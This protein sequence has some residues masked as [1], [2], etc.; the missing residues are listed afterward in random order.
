MN[1][2]K[3]NSKS[4]LSPEEVQKMREELDSMKDEITRVAN[5]PDEPVNP[6]DSTPWRVISEYILSVTIAISLAFLINTFILLNAK[7]PSGSMENT[8]MTGDRIFGF[9]LAYMF[10]EPERGDIIIFKFP[11]NEKKNYIKRVI[12]LPGETVTIRDGL[13]YINDNTVPLDEPYLAE[14]PYSLD[15]GPYE[16]PEDHYFMLGDNRNHSSDSRAWKNTFVSK[17]KILAKAFIRYW[18]GVR[19]YNGY[20]YQQGE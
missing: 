20:D 18:G 17:D 13:I 10:N 16:V 1:F 11:D 3:S 5:I 4:S 9:R 14:A 19:F 15:F 7:I 12:G 2:L 6:K 8:I